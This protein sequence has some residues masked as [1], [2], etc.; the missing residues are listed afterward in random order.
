L[1]ITE[2]DA[3]RFFMT[4]SE[5][6]SLILESGSDP[7]GGEVSVLDMGDPVRI[8]DLARDLVQLNGLDPDLVQFTGTGLRPGER[9]DEKLFYDDESAAPT[10]HPGI[11]QARRSGAD[12][13]DARIETFVDE[14]AAAAREHDDHEVR[15]LLAAMGSLT[16]M[17]AQAG[18]PTVVGS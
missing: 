13:T 6:V 8:M 17:T 3:T 11:L 14:L 10:R 7:E 1:T 15:A 5:A 18:S 9:L 4:I 16:G 12:D 2:P